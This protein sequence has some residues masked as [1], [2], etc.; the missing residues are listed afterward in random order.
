MVTCVEKF[1]PRHSYLEKSSP[2]LPHHPVTYG[3]SLA[4]E[5]SK[6]AARKMCSLARTIPNKEV[7]LV[8]FL[9]F[10]IMNPNSYKDSDFK[11]HLLFILVSDYNCAHIHTHTCICRVKQGKGTLV[12]KKI[13][14]CS[15][16]VK[17]FSP[18][19]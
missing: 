9:F 13:R 10:L 11:C 4:A 3:G 15:K 14:G 5:P 6:L 12:L 17:I 8:I 18:R 7:R 16:V 2:C 19:F 1:L